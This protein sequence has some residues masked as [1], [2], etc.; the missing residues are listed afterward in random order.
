LKAVN[1][2]FAWNVDVKSIRN[3]WKQNPMPVSASNANLPLKK[4]KIRAA[5][6]GN[7]C[8]MGKIR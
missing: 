6:T 5:V 2:V 3:V 4:W 8:K 7:R 1:T